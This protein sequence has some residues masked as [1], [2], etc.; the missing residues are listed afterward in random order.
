MNS[1]GDL[2][3]GQAGTSFQSYQPALQ[4]H[5]LKSS[6]NLTDPNTHP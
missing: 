2:L 3:D 1:N 4:Y 6:L 5:L